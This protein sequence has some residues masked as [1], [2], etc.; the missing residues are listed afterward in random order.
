MIIEHCLWGDCGEQERNILMQIDEVSLYPSWIP[1]QWS[2]LSFLPHLLF[3]GR[4]DKIINAFALYAHLPQDPQ[5]HLLKIAVTEKAR[6][7]QIGTKILSHS[8]DY[9]KE[10]G[11]TSLY[12][13]VELT[14]EK[15]IGLYEK[16]GLQRLHQKKDYYGAGRDAWSMHL[17]V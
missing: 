4:Q 10:Q 1:E 11:K 6:G 15:A 9:W 12:L 5:V 14:N 3:I 17:S 16:L 13:E 8:W 7:Q 2:G